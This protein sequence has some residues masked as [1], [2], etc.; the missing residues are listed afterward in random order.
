MTQTSRYRPAFVLLFC[1]LLTACGPADDATGKRVDASGKEA[2]SLEAVPAEVLQAAQAVRPEMQ[3]L[4]AEHEVREGRDYYDIAGKMPDGA[5]VEL[6]MTTVDGRWAVVEIQ[7]DIE[8]AQVPAQVRQALT[9]A[10]QNWVPHRI[11]ESDQDNGVVIYE[12]FGAG[13]GAEEMKAEVKW[14]ANQAELLKDE[15]VH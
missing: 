1:L 13:P 11:I 6:D 4:A 10:H 14:E 15:W 5:E 7:R 8:M 3:L 12:F 9:D 2:T